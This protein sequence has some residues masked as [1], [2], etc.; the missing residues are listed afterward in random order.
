MTK[1]YRV[2]RINAEEANLSHLPE[3]T[4]RYATDADVNQVRAQVKATIEVGSS[5][6]I[7]VREVASVSSL[8]MVLT[9]Y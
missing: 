7:S 3:R 2:S 6:W 1:T 8:A 5:D 4:F 9:N